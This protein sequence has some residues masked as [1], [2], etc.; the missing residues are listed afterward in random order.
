MTIYENIRYGRDDVDYEQIIQ[1][2]KMAYAHVF[3][4]ALPQGYDTLVGERGFS[5]FSG[6]QIQSKNSIQKI[7]N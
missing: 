5:Q 6:G 2:A 3:I 1:A 4:S 7:L